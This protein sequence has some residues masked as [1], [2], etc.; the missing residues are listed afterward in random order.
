[1]VSMGEKFNEILRQ[2]EEEEKHRTD[3]NLSL[4]SIRM[5]DEGKLETKEGRLLTLGEH[6]FSTFCTELRLPA[7]Y[8][9]RLIVEKP[10]FVAQQVNYF[11]QKFDDNSRRKFRLLNDKVQGIVSERYV[12]YD[13]LQLFGTVNDMIDRFPEGVIT[14]FYRDDKRTQ[15]RIRFPEISKNMGYAEEDGNT[16]ELVGGITIQNSQVGYSRI[17][18]VP[19]VW[20]KVC[21]NGMM[22][23]GESDNG[24][25]QRHIHFEPTSI[26]QQIED[27]V[28]VAVDTTKEL[29]NKMELAREIKIEKPFDEL[30]KYS[31][32]LNLNKK[33][34]GKLEEAFYH[35]PQNNLYGVIN[36]FTRFARDLKNNEVQT[37]I[38]M[39]A[40]KLLRQVA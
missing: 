3:L 20:R 1:M 12:P 27:G 11:L 17:M 15:M 40:G 31:K 34:T 26:R 6:A 4:N 33:Q 2:L 7:N 8:M 22:G 38:E 39:F 29:M 28:L 18:C 16:D 30:K 32:Q 19:L 25:R 36:A 14:G 5:S 21:S 23:W 10:D 24:L 37:D 13:D 9:R 35:E